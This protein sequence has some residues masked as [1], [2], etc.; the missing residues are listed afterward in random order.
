MRNTI[1]FG[2]SSYY[3]LSELINDI[4][5]TLKEKDKIN[6]IGLLDDNESLIGTSILNVPVLGRVDD[7][8]KILDCEFYIFGIGSHKTHILR[9]EIILNLGIDKK[10]FLTLIHPS[11]KIFSTSEVGEGSIIHFGS[12]VFNNTTIGP[13]TIIMA[14]TVI[15]AHNLVGEGCLITSSVSTTNGVKIGNYS[16]IGTKSAI[17]ENV[18]ISPGSKISMCSQVRKNT[19]PGEFVFSKPSKGVK[20]SVVSSTLI[21][22]WSVFK[23]LNHTQ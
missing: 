16:F 6:I 9:R 22:E 18:E 5:D 11:V 8:R 10:K 3:E 7:Y 4:N 19:V 1:I 17:S 15:G 2:A 21:N 20:L 12:I 13:F 23:S 14:L